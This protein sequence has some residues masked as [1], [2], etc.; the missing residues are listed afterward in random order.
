M[1][2]ELQAGTNDPVPTRRVAGEIIPIRALSSDV[3]TSLVAAPV[4]AALPVAVPTVAMRAPDP[5]DASRWHNHAIGGRSY[6]IAQPVTFTPYASAMPCSARCRFCSETLVEQGSKRP[7]S[8]LRPSGAYF[9]QLREAL[10]QLE[11]L[12]LSYSL[13]G[14]ETTDDPDW[15]YRMLDVLEGH[16]AVSP[17]QGRVLYSNGAGLAHPAHGQALLERLA[18]FGVDW[19]EL[20]RHHADAAVNQSIMRF[21][22]GVHVQRQ[23][24][25]TGMLRSLS[26]RLPVKLVCIVQECGVASPQDLLHYLAWARDLGVRAVIF[27]EFSQLDERYRDNV[28]ARYIASTRVAMAG[29]LEGCLALPDFL[30]R[31]TCEQVTEGYYFWNLVGR[32]GD[33]RVTF[34]ASDYARMHRQHQSGDVYKLVFHANGK[35]CA[36][37]N[38]DQNVLFEAGREEV[39]HG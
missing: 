3:A 37:W 7:A 23:A 35:L 4:L 24:A 10:Q 5:L 27:R 15:L 22:P 34:E 26:E 32:Y 18:R 36:G 14:L 9:S 17:V 16:A 2:A 19:V 30:D 39:R 8:G 13:S 29:L 38:P 11:G 12:P 28:T 33:M 6:R 20:S 25:F 31:F 21:R 1:Q